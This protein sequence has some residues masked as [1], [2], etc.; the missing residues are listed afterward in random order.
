MSVSPK[1]TS[2]DLDQ[3]LV[4]QGSAGKLT[5][6]AADRERSQIDA[7]E[8]DPVDERRSFSLCCGIVA[9]IACELHH[10]ECR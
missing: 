5:K 9:G 2:A 10:T 8:A 1:S 3:I 4:R 7:G 6:L